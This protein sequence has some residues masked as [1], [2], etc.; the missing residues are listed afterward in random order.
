MIKYY[1]RAVCLTSLILETVSI[2]YASPVQ[3]TSH[4]FDLTIEELL[5]LEIQSPASMTPT[6]SQ[7]DPAAV[8]TITHL[9]IERSGARDL[10]ELLEIFVPN[11]Q[12]VPHHWEALHMGAR[13]IISHRDDK[14]LL[15]VNGKVMNN[16]MHSGA[17]SE[18][19]LP[20]LNDI[21]RVDVIRGAG[22][23]VHGTGAV[24]MVI[25]ITTLTAKQAEGTLVALQA[26][27]GNDYQSLEIRH[28]HNW[29]NEH[30][31]LVYGGLTHQEGADN[32]SAP[33]VYGKDSY[34][35]W[36][37]SI[38][39]GE[40]SDL[41]HPN[42]GA[43]YLGQ[44]KVKLHAEYQYSNANLWAR[45]TRSGE[46]L[47]W[48]P[49]AVASEQP[50]PG[51]SPDD[52]YQ[53][54]AGHQQLTIVGNYQH[55]FS[56]TLLGTLS[57]SYDLF[58]N[59]RRLFDFKAKGSIDENAGVRTQ[60]EGLENTREEEYLAQARVNWQPHNAH[61][62]SFGVDYAY[63]KWGDASDLSSSEQGVSFVLGETDM[64][65]THRYA[66]LTEYQ[67]RIDSQWTTYLGVRMDDDTYTDKMYSP[68]F[69]SI[70]S[71]NERDTFKFI[72]S[73]SSRK[74][75]A[76]ELRDQYIKDVDTKPEVLQSAEFIYQAVIDHWFVGTTVFYNALDLIT[77]EEHTR[78]SINL[79]DQRTGGIE[80]ELS[81]QTAD[82]RLQFSHSY[83]KLLSF[84]LYDESYS[85]GVTSAPYG[86][87]DDLNNW[88]NNISKIFLFGQF[89]P[90]WSAS[91]SLRIFWEYQGSEDYAAY[92]NYSD[93]GYDEPFGLSAFWNANTA[94]RFNKHIKV[95]LDGYNLLGLIDHTYNKRAYL[96]NVS[97]YRAD[98]P[99]V[100]LMFIST[101]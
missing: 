42:D 58:D 87:G 39:A 11:T 72:L 54:Q 31:L 51:A 69:A 55:K 73:Q 92:K 63:E 5:L 12:F 65:T 38:T 35:K 50:Q 100:R 67:W 15:M 27:G 25:N 93:E 28:G 76:E 61:L 8:S 32:D 62:L 2:A 7:Q 10:L 94:Y 29:S 59:E 74:N 1:Y 68:R 90:A 66:L 30:S 17:L 14:Y 3:M 26:A 75:L 20:M 52:V 86:V 71:P 37:D 60:D 19:N 98:A 46:T 83:T 13:G 21:A 24:S 64:W 88:S 81:Y 70:F 47:V 9:D 6:T 40:K 34:T 22:S 48:S 91:T 89:N 57:L 33:V 44:P 77:F 95:Q 56:D 4:Y 45:Y 36:G 23:V 80:F 79:A 53:Q 99:T 84:E 16:Q 49:Y 18:R 41:N 96:Y 43:S 85:Q 82:W 101:F 78:Q 97:N